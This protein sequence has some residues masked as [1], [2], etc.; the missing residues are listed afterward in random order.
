MMDDER[1]Y[2]DKIV[3][4][5]RQEGPEG[6]RIEKRLTPN[7]EHIKQ[8]RFH[9]REH[10]TATHFDVTAENIIPAGAHRVFGEPRR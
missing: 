3:E 4:L 1:T 7:G 9:K 5:L 2:Y 8:I 6:W 10:E